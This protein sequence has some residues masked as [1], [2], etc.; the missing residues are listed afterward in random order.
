MLLLLAVT[1]SCNRDEVFEKEQYKNVFALISEHDYNVFKVV[2]DLDEPESVGYVAAVCGGT[3]PTDRKI[4]ITLVEDD[5]L[6]DSYNKGNYD[7]DVEKYAKRLPAS[8]YNIDNFNF[9]IPAGERFGQVKIRIRP[10]GLSPD[11]TYFISLKVSSFSDYEVNPDKT[12]ILYEVV[13]KNR[14]ATRETTTNYQLRGSR[15]NVETYSVKTVH[16]LSSNRVRIMAG[17]DAFQADVAEINRRGLILEVGADDRVTILPYKDIV[18]TQ[19][20]GDREFANIFKIEDDGYKTYKTF[21]LYYKYE[22]GG[23]TV[24]MKEELRLEFKEDEL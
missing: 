21:M 19:I 12:N 10:E 9:T 23:S 8:M 24:E 3:N 22:D 14:Y 18:V 6:F 4:D 5:E 1:V 2:H 15:N 13:I 20:D 17:I 7:Q 11:S 16:P